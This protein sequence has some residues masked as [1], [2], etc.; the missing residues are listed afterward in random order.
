MLSGTMILLVLVIMMFGFALLRKPQAIKPALKTARKH[1]LVL[2]LRLP[3]ALLSAAFIAIILPSDLA[4]P[5]IGPETGVWGILIATAFGAVVPGGPILTFPLALVIW[6][7]GAG[8]A[9]MVAFLASWS[10]FA[11]HRILSYELP[12]LGARFVVVRLASSWMLPPLAG[13]IAL[14]LIAV[15]GAGTIS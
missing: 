4:G 15:F 13:F 12:L 6:R 2:G 3:L 1:I 14:A 8:E 10:I 11:V 7:S 5:L 9:Q